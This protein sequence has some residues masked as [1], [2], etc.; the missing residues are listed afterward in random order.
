VSVQVVRNSA[1]S[2]SWFNNA[3]GGINTR[4]RV[5]MMKSPRRNQGTKIS[6]R[7]TSMAWSQVSQAGLRIMR[8]QGP[9]LINIASCGIW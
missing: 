2:T 5:T 7:S 6:G 1:G 8:E 9:A 4:H 3:G